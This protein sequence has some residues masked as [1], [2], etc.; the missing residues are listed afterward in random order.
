MR[1]ILGYLR[2]IQ[3][4]QSREVILGGEVQMGLH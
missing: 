4:Y 1:N 3:V 2:I